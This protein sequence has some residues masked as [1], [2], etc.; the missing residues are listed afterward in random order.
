VTLAGAW[1]QWGVDSAGILAS[2][3]KATWGRHRPRS[4]IGWMALGTAGAAAASCAAIALSAI[5]VCMA[6]FS[7]VLLLAMSTFGA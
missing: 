5:L 6:G 1:V 3:A 4:T 2:V 7:V